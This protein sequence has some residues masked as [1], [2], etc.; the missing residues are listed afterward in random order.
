[1]K[2]VDSRRIAPVM[3]TLPLSYRIDMT[4][5]EAAQIARFETQKIFT[6]E[7]LESNLN[8]LEDELQNWIKIRYR[9]YD[10]EHMEKRESYLRR[11][12]KAVKKAWEN[13]KMLLK[14]AADGE[15]L[16]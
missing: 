1:M 10:Y 16:E 11:N 4:A 13:Y 3:H 6:I 8:R 9:P 7:I 5:V 2:V 15:T 12:N 14:L